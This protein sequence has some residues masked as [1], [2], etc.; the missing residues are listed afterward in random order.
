[1]GLVKPK[2]FLGQHFLKDLSIAKDIADT[3]D[4]CPGLPILEVGPGMGVLTQ[5]LMEKG[6]EVKVVELDFESVA[7]L[8]ENFPALEGNIIEDDFLKLKLEKLFDG[9]PFV[10]TGN[11]PYN[12]SSQIFFKM[13]DYKDLIPC[14]TGMIQK[15][16]AERIAAGPGSKTYGIL[17]ILIQAWYKVEYLFT[18]HEH[19]FNPPPKVKSAVIRMT[20]NETKELGCNERLFKLIVK[21]T[22]N[23]RR[24][25]L[26]NSISS[27]LEKGNPLSNDPVF[28]KRPEQLSVQEFI[29][30]TNRV[31]TA[32]K[33]KADID[34]GNDIAR[35][36]ATSQKE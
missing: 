27:I 12:I 24:K 35:K 20:R 6:R 22:F 34:C 25:T 15:E 18:V 33:D 23:Q 7:Y 10:L 9:R 28:N 30:L 13:L 14:C 8:R 3:V 19:V 16:V 36:G 21:T 32:L 26:R 11:Y 29:E 2:K 1:M 17:S 31:E 4:E 5:F